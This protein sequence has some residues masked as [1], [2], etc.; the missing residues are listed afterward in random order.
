MREPGDFHL[1]RQWVEEAG[2][3]G[4]GVPF[5]CA[6]RLAEAYRA[7]GLPLPEI[8]FAAWRAWDGRAESDPAADFEAAT[9]AERAKALRAWRRLDPA[10]AREALAG[11]G[12][13]GREALAAAG[14]PQG[15]LRESASN[16][17][18]LLAC[19]AEGLG[20]DD[21]PFLQAAI[22][23]R[24]AEVRAAAGALLA[25]LPGSA[26]GQVLAESARRH[27]RFD[28]H[29]RLDV[30]A[31]RDAGVLADDWL[32]SAGVAFRGGS[33]GRLATLVGAAPLRAWDSAPPGTWVAA[34]GRTRWSEEL[35]LG[36]AVAAR[37]ERDRNWALALAESLRGGMGRGDAEATASVALSALQAGEWEEQVAALL[38]GCD[39]AAAMRILGA[40]PHAGW[41][42]GF[43]EVVAGHLPRMATKHAADRWGA[44][45]PLDA[46]ALRAAPSCAGRLTD[47]ADRNEANWPDDLVERFRAAASTLARRKS[48]ADAFN[49]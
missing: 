38:P 22:Q 42:G 15:F 34:A 43:S 30:D 44:R 16:R 40:S 49:R 12:G 13:E 32:A 3:R 36:W 10:A 28:S 46:V 7:K 24:S 20:P 9:G 8:P 25:A 11:D 19:L 29:G 39:L 45:V 14:L 21:E 1:A 33:D 26:Y 5:E 4:Y 31:P 18:T 48:I 23:D 41:S 2:R 6:S 35:R 17:A 37:R 27:V 47:A